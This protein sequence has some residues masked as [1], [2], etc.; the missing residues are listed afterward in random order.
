MAV[1][2]NPGFEVPELLL[3]IKELEEQQSGSS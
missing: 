2:T 1:S 3:R